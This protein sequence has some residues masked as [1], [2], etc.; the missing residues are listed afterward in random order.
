MT[1][2]SAVE[3][4]QIFHKYGEG[5]NLASSAFLVGDGVE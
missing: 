1:F 5:L 4:V 3:S 2:R